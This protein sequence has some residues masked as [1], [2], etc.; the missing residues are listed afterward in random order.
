M[1]T[2][3]STESEPA[4][5]REKAYRAIRAL[6]V[7]GELGTSETISERKL[8]ERFGIGRTP[9]REALRR[10]T[11]E[12]LLHVV[13][14]QGTF[15][16][17]MSFDDLREIHE[18]RIALEGMAAFLAAAHGVTPEMAECAA[19]LRKLRDK[20]DPDHELSQSLGWRF[21]DALFVASRN[22]RLMAVYDALRA[23]S[24][25]AL[26]KLRNYDRLRSRQTVDEHLEIFDAV[27]KGDS[28]LAQERMRTHLAR[29]FQ[30]R[31]QALGRPLAVDG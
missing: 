21:H 22:G 15:V 5:D 17:T 25:L 6:V 3:M 23:Q 14:M 30:A 11:E 13:P 31:L 18:M 20:T 10:L 24:G 8:S 4:L 2:K 1:I 28:A 29:A 16:R 27:E 19:G 7:D 26:R 9:V 12:G